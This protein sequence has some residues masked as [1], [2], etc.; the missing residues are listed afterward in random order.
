MGFVTSTYELFSFWEPRKRFKL[1]RAWGIAYLGQFVAAVYFEALQRPN[2]TLIW[3]MPLTGMIQSI[4]ASCT[5]TFMPK[6]SSMT[7]RA[8]AEGFFNETS[9]M[10]Y[11]FI[12]EN[13]Y[14]ALLLLWQS[15]YLCFSEQIRRSLFFL[16]FELVMTFYPYYMVRSFFPKT[17]FRNSTNSKNVTERTY[18][19]VVKS[20]YIF[21]K[22]FSGYYVN[23]LNF[24]GLFGNNPIMEWS[25]L[26]YLLI[27]AGWGT[28]IAIFLQ[29]LKFRK[30]ISLRTNAILYTGSFPFFYLGYGAL[31]TE[32]LDR[33]WL[34]ALVVIGAVVNFGPRSGQIA[35]QTLMCG[36]LVYIRFGGQ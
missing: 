19:L 13:V 35:W 1:H 24:L 29:T 32:T 15:V 11:D 3:T 6:A 2:V 17:Q 20:F 12:L 26:R 16:P 31:I 21:A 30:Y 8:K 23:Y 10:S 25:M 36:I 5:F 34:S 14:F 18:A 22:H 7:S 27:L 9:A 33:V 28:T 4:I